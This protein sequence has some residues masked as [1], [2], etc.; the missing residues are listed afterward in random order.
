MWIYRRMQWIW[1][2]AIKFRVPGKAGDE[3]R[4]DNRNK[5]IYKW[6]IM[7]RTD[8]R[9]K[10]DKWSVMKRELMIEVIKK[11][12]KWNILVTLKDLTLMRTILEGWRKAS[13][14]SAVI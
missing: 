10:K 3:K 7:K 5:K 8:D 6:N 13:E 14:R 11:I 2:Q 12:D 1:K 9:N 4:A